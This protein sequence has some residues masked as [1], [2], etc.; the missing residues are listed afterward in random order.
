[1][2]IRQEHW[3]VRTGLLAGVAA[4]IASAYWWHQRPVDRGASKTPPTSVFGVSWKTGADNKNAAS[5]VVARPAGKPHNS[6]PD[7]RQQLKDRKDWF[8]LAQDILP[9]AKAGNPEAQYVLYRAIA[10]CAQTPVGDSVE[11][12]R[13]AQRIAFALNGRPEDNLVIAVENEAEANQIRCQGFHTPAAAA[14]GDDLDWLLKAMD[15]GYAPALAAGARERVRQDRSMATVRAGGGDPDDP[16]LKLPPI[17]GDATPHELLLAAVKSGDSEVLNDIANTVYMLDPKLTHEQQML[18]HSAWTYVYCQRGDGCKASPIESTF[19][20]PPAT[21]MNCGP[22]DRYC[23]PIP[24]TLLMLADYNWEP[25]QEVVNQ[26]NAALD[27]KQREQL[28]GLT[29]GG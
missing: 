4:V 26:I 15:Q 2:A 9:Q 20:E 17:G 14:L 13:A 18:L 28:P 21:V 25:V 19:D 27:A 7:L 8:A 10:S 12:V 23:T 1:M 22:N 11:A 24:R 3:I 16:R 6:P 29:A 5:V